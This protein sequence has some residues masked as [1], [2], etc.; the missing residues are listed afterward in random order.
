MSGVQNSRIET[1]LGVIRNL[2]DDIQ[3]VIGDRKVFRW[4]TSEYLVLT[5]KEFERD[6]RYI[7]RRAGSEGIHFLTVELPRLGKWYDEV[8]AQRAQYTPMGFKPYWIS[9]NWNTVPRFC[10]TLWYVIHEPVWSSVDKARVIQLYRSLFFCFYKLE[11]PLSDEDL[12]SALN[13]WLETE[14]FL[15]EFQFPDYFDSDLTL[16]REVICDVFDGQTDALF[17]DI[18][19]KHGPGAVAGGE[20]NQGKWETIN[21]IPTL[22]CRY[23]RYDMYLG[24]RSGGRISPEMLE[25]ILSV[26]KRSVE[27]EAVSR[28]LFVPKD[29][30]GPRTISCEPKELMFAQ[31]GVAQNLMELFHHR[32]AGRINFIDQTINGNLAKLSSVSQEFAT[33]DLKD[34]SDRVSTALVERVFP[35][36]VLPW[37][38][39]LRSTSTLLPDGTVFRNHRKFAPMGSA[40]CF[41]IESLLFWAIAVVACRK[42]GCSYAEAMRRV[43]VYGDDIIIPVHAVDELVSLMAKF[44]LEVNLSKTYARGPFRESCGV[45]A[46]NGHL[47][48]PLRVKKDICRRPLDAALA[49]AICEYSSSCFTKFDARKT[50]EYFYNLVNSQYDG[51]I[52]HL[53]P[54]GCLSVVDP[55]AHCFDDTSLKW[56]WNRSLCR[57]QIYTWVVSEGK[58]SCRLT[59]LPRLLRSYYGNWELHNPSQVVDPRSA[60][61]RKRKFL[62]GRW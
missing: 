4:D 1:L 16:T 6:F 3:N 13:K 43:Y 41:P 30:R 62:V 55:H 11:M 46:W 9:E 27:T 49:V 32:T 17:R 18:R 34:A 38:H 21:K 57:S 15:D 59:G 54:L 37:L 39:A 7:S 8:L 26:T 40:I 35:D 44:A 23:P 22:H 61:I 12:S 10:R 14:R 60:K 48:T 24:W 53:R 19:M 56:S 20:D 42:T 47:V 25:E 36:W 2:L 29:S 45:D 28:L 58:Q 51:V 31:Q 5:P 52:R 50:G 33:V